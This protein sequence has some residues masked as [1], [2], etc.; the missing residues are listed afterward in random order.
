MVSA[1]AYLLSISTLFNIVA[2]QGCD[3]IT[4]RKEIHDMTSEEVKVFRDTIRLAINTKDP[5]S[6]DGR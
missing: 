3:K 4:T 5:E 2:S 1:F 6:A